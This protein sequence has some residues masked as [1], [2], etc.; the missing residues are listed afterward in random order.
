LNPLPAFLFAALTL[1]GQSAPPPEPLP[2]SEEE[3]EKVIAVIHRRAANA[4]ARSAEKRR[5]ATELSEIGRV[6]LAEGQVGRATE[7]LGEAYGLD[8]ENGL[9]LAVL[10]LAY[11]RAEDFDS[12]RF[13]LHRAEERVTQAPPEAYGVLGDIY[14]ALNRLDDAVVAWGESVR[15]GGQDPPLLR[16]LAR[17]RDE[18]ALT[19]GQRTLTLDH[20]S[21]FADP[22][23]SETVVRRAGASLEAAYREQSS[24][25][26]AGLPGSQI[27]ILYAG[28]AYFSLVSVPDWVSGL[29]D[30]KIRVSVEPE[31]T[32]PSPVSAVLFHELAH[33]L[34][35]HVSHDRA[36]GWL[37]EGLAQ[38]WEGKRI[39]HREVKAALGTRRPPSIETLERS[40]RGKL[41]R[42]SARSSY[43]Q[44]LS[45]VE[46]LIALRGPGAVACVAG[47]LAEGL[48][49]SDALQAETGFSPGEIFDGWKRWAGL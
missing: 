38:W 44:A 13:Y 5:L 19:R 20:F 34:V 29:F 25:F 17:A 47:R 15:F 43:A 1:A 14:Y 2:R 40:F 37:H 26:G 39:P 46:Y 10:T 7:L 16:R 36:P 24:F 49:I 41:D 18:L 35:R 33:A 32:A 31:E 28:R 48:S 23:I 30:G 22:A 45:L 12:A 6:Y 42:A 3:R 11:V 9:V 4:A 21:I 27:V 8:E